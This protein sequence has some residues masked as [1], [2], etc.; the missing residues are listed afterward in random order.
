M[1]CWIIQKIIEVNQLY[2]IN[3]SIH[4]LQNHLQNKFLK[5]T[6]EIKLSSFH[7]IFE[8]VSTSSY[9]LQPIEFQINVVFQQ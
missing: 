9:N 2:K 7:S 4:Y 3:K 5:I 6:F 1:H 8:K